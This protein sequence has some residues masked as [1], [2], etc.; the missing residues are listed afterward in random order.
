VNEFIIVIPHLI[1][2]LLSY[3]FK[4]LYLVPKRRVGTVITSLCEFLVENS[5]AWIRCNCKLKFNRELRYPK[6]CDS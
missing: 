1:L 3:L 4:N 6:L 5:F 2:Y